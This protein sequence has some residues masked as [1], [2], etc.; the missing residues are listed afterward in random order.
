MS[1]LTAR[2][3]S[4]TFCAGCKQPIEGACLVTP[5]GRYHPSHLVCDYERDCCN[6]MADYYQVGELKVCLEH[7]DAAVER[8]IRQGGRQAAGTRAER[9]QTRLMQVERKSVVEAH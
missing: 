1:R 7:A 4:G 5:A 8:A 6:A 9:R 3:F 2:C